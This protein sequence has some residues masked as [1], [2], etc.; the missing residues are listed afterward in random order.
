MDIWQSTTVAPCAV[1]QACIGPLVLWFRY[2]DGEVQVVQTYEP[3]TS[4][5]ELHGFK[6]CPDGLPAGLNWSRW[7]TD[8]DA[9]HVRLSACLPN[10]AVVVRTES[11]VKILPGKEALFYVSLPIWIKLLVGKAQGTELCDMPSVV[12]SNTWFGDS[13]E[14]ELCYSLVTRARR[15]IEEAD[16]PAHKAYCPVKIKNGSD[17]RLDIER[18]C[19]RVEHLSLYESKGM[20]WSNE[21][22]ISFQGEGRMGQVNYSRNKPKLDAEVK[23]LTPPRTPLKE[24]LLRRSV[25]SF[26]GLNDS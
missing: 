9:H 10:R 11:P 22:A 18:F 24:T 16:Q 4:E 14:G 23:L 13:M 21:V 6:A 26:V 17:E 7:I 25:G 3:E 19:V 15:T 8:R 12:R 2:V 20:L 5:S 1:Y